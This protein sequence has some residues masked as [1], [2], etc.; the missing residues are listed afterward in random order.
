MPEAVRYETRA[1]GVATIALDQP[2]TRNALSDE[3]LDE[4]IAAF[5]RARDDDAVRC[6]VLA[7]HARDASSAPAATSSGF[8][9][10]VPLVH[11]HSAIERFPR[12]VRA[13]RRA[14]QAD[15]LRGGR[16]RAGGRARRRAGLRPRVAKETRDVRHA[17]DQRRRLP[18]HD[19]GADLPQRPAQEDQRAAAARRADRRARGRAAR[20]RQPGRRRT[21]SST[22]PSPTGRR[23]LAAK[24][25]AA[26][27]AGQGRDVAPA[28]P[29]ADG[30][31]RLPAL[32]ADARRSRPR[33]SRRASRAF[34]EKREPLWKGR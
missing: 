32:A 12:A 25:P 31:A 4:L 9:A 13:D 33:T 16:P 2:D 30:R 22:P 24:S 28:G 11:K 19:H 10:D 23:R 18:V 3:L 29:G 20:D 15:A 1:D 8:A 27:A 5:E 26:D 7:S 34:F 17:G 14:R 6:V 21:T